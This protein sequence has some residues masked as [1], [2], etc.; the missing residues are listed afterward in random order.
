M[1][2]DHHELTMLGTKE[3]LNASRQICRQLMH[4]LIQV[5][6]QNGKVQRKKKRVMK[7]GDR[8]V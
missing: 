3:S 5:R 6:L 7:G 4:E 8:N 2:E 1:I